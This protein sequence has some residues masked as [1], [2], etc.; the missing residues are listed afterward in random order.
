MYFYKRSFKKGL[1]FALSAVLLA[2]VIIGCTSAPAPTPTPEPAAATAAAATATPAP[3]ATATPAPTVAPA[4]TREKGYVKDMGGR[5]IRLMCWWKKQMATD[6]PMPDPGVESDTAFMNYAADIVIWDLL[7]QIEME[8][9]C[10]IVSPVISWGDV[11]PTLTASI[12]S[13][14]PVCDMMWLGPSWA[15]SCIKNDLIYPLQDVCAPD[16]DVLNAQKFTAVCSEYNGLYYT[17]RDQKPRIPNFCLGVNLDI[18]NAIGAENPIDLFDK[19]MWTFDK[20]REILQLATRDTSGDGTIDQ[21]GICGHPQWIIEPLIASNDGV[22]I[23]DDMTY[24]LDDPRTMTA[25]ELVYQIY[26]VDKTFYYDESFGYD[27][28]EWD[29]TANAFLDAK[30]AFWAFPFY[31]IEDFQP[32]CAYAA[33]PFPKGPDN[34]GGFVSFSGFKEGYCVPRGTIDPEDVT[35]IYDRMNKWCEADM[36]LRDGAIFEWE[37]NCFQSEEDYW[38]LYNGMNP[39]KPDMGTVIDGYTNIYGNLSRVFHFGEM[40]PA[41]AVETYKQEYQNIIDEIM[42]AGD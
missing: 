34:K 6:D 12:M 41:Q 27:F 9:N 2:A 30:T 32:D 28:G 4:D 5:E 10:K 40:T 1:A 23:N 8:Y 7:Q 3:A 11:M 18:I 36:D 37:I 42:N 31:Q 26:T 15:F 33:I 29:P 19:G 24:G 39:L 17:M 14:D 20:F 25:L 38:R 13:G 35:M 22:L 21:W 16:S